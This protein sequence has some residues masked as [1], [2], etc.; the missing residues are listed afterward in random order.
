MKHKKRLLKWITDADFMNEFDLATIAN[1][2]Y[3]LP[4]EESNIDNFAITKALK[5][6]V[7]KLGLVE[8]KQTLWVKDMQ[9]GE[10]DFKH[11]LNKELDFKL[12]SFERKFNEH[13]AYME[14][15]FDQKETAD[16]D[17]AIKFDEI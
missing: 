16:K 8:H 13:Q 1:H 2:P 7:Y 5:C 14:N 17:R 10:I 11:K 3:E 4:I 12:S 9:T 6:I 15:L